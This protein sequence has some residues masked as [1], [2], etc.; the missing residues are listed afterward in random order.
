MGTERIIS[1]ERLRIAF[2]HVEGFPA[3]QRL[4]VENITTA[5][6]EVDCDC[7]SEGMRAGSHFYDTCLSRFARGDNRGTDRRLIVM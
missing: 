4:Q 7:V 1:V 3:A 6:E 2:H 5:A